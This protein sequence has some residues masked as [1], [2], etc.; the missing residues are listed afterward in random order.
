MDAIPRCRVGLRVLGLL[1]TCA[2]H[3]GC[4]GYREMEWKVRLL[5]DPR[6]AAFETTFY[7]LYGADST[8]ADLSQDALDLIRTW[9]SDEYLLERIDEG[10]Y[11][12]ERNVWLQDGELVGFESGL[13]A[14][15]EEVE[16]FTELGTDSI[17]FR[18]E[19]SDIDQ[20]AVLVSTN[21]SVSESEAGHEIVSWLPG[22]REFVLR[23]RMPPAGGPAMDLTAELE[24]RLREM[25]KPALVWR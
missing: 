4:L 16:V 6:Q 20:D 7:G 2:L 8:A 19:L 9:H 15:L 18:I 17:A 12:R 1:T 3:S 14:D 13:C 21:G 23:Y 10:I 24:A 22:T 11:V 25:G 5:E